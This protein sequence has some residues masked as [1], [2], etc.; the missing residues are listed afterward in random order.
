[1]V[2]QKCKYRIWQGAEEKLSRWNARQD[3]RGFS[4]SQDLSFTLLLPYQLPKPLLGLRTVRGGHSFSKQHWHS[5]LPE[6]NRQGESLPATNLRLI[7]PCPFLTFRSHGSNKNSG[8]HIAVLYRA[9]FPLKRTGRAVWAHLCRNRNC[10]SLNM[11]NSLHTNKPTSFT[12]WF[13]YLILP[14]THLFTFQITWI[15][16]SILWHCAGKEEQLRRALP[17]LDPAGTTGE[18]AQ[19]FLG[20]STAL[21]PTSCLPLA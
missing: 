9:K 19:F 3:W 8:V 2:A 12:Y 17:L 11:E 14:H 1:M 18:Y 6:E 15:G 20:L 5:L 10:L 7:L 4:I 16:L 21:F 13:Y